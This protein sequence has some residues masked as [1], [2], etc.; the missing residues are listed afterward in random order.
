ME[1]FWSLRLNIMKTCFPRRGSWCANMMLRNCSSFLFR[2]C[3]DTSLFMTLHAGG[4]ARA[5][6]VVL[7]SN[8]VGSFCNQEISL[9]VFAPI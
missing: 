6:P 5:L 9:D 1:M 4:W 2:G 3:Q 7:S 8:T